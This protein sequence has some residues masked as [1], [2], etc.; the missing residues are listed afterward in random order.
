VDGPRLDRL[1]GVLHRTDGARSVLERICVVCVRSVDADGAGVS[2]YEAGRYRVLA[3]SDGSAAAVEE[4]QVE[5]AEGPCVTARALGRP[6]LEPDLSS[7]AALERWPRFAPAALDHGV[8][9]VFAFPLG[10]TG[11][12]VGALDVYVH[13]PGDLAGEYYED[14]M[15]L[16]DLASLA[17]TA[18][19]GVP[20]IAGS[21]AVAE[22]GEPWA[23]PAV[24]HQASGMVSEQLGVDADAALLRLRALAFVSGRSVADV[25]LDVV[26]RRLRLDAWDADE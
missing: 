10:V 8:A 11:R 4:L 9:A 14:A 15:M 20:T 5:M 18:T 19:A 6:F 7:P 2:G 3:A 1:L 17:A 25:S 12:S 16:A 13:H 23:H 26:E 22:P 21:D 24:V